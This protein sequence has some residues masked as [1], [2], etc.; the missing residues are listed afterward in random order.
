M[1]SQTHESGWVSFAPRPTERRKPSSRWMRPVSGLRYLGASRP[2]SATW[3]RPEPHARALRAQDWTRQGNA[4]EARASSARSP[5][6]G[7][8]P[9]TVCACAAAGRC[10]TGCARPRNAVPSRDRD[11]ADSGPALHER[12]ARESRHGAVRRRQVIRG[13]APTRIEGHAEAAHRPSPDQRLEAHLRRDRVDGLGPFQKTGGVTVLRQELDA[14]VTACCCGVEVTRL[15]A[16][17]HIRMGLDHDLAVGSFGE[18]CIQHP[19]EAGAIGSAIPDGRI[20]LSLIADENVAA[21]ERETVSRPPL[22]LEAP[23]PHQAAITAH[24]RSD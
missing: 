5:A 9:E 1:S 22:Y 10:G 17:Q 23:D 14:R 13:H 19:S 21:R 4:Q 24:A 2:Q 7:S 8:G 12:A 15:P 11:S 16:R 6:R 3:R 18:C 20:R